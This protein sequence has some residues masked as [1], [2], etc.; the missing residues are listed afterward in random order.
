MK[1]SGI[2]SAVLLL[3]MPVAISACGTQD[4]GVGDGSTGSKQVVVDEQQPTKRAEEI[5]H[6]AVDGMSPKPTLKRT[7]LRPM[8]ACPAGDDHGSGDRVRLR[9]S[10]QLT[11]V[12]G[13]KAKGEGLAVITVTSPCF[14]PGGDSTADTVAPRS[15]HP[16]ER[17]GRRALDRSSRAYDALQVRHASAAQDGEGLSS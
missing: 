6:R 3:P 11:G 2:R 1:L 4:G 9:L 8:E 13:S 7:M 16:D 12:P 10:Y 15:S 14:A 5:I 17:A